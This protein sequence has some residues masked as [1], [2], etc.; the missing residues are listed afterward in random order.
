MLNTGINP[1]VHGVSDEM[2][3]TY[4]SEYHWLLTYEKIYGTEPTAEAFSHKF[5]DF[6][7]QTEAVDIAFAA[8]EVISEYTRRELVK[9]INRAADHIEQ[10]DV[11]QAMLAVSSFIPPARTPLITND[12]S[13]L[14]FLTE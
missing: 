5:P 6:P 9:S 1:E 4:G 11:E 7:L 13:S 8:E 2:M 3:A 10:G 14:G 12:L